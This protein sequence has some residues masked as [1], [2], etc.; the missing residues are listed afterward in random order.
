MKNKGNDYFF[1]QTRF[2]IEEMILVYCVILSILFY[3]FN[4]QA[5]LA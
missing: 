1:A 4:N 3:K 2:M 5:V